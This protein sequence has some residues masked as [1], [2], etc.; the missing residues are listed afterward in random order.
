MST[1]PQ[2]GNPESEVNSPRENAGKNG[3]RALH[4]PFAFLAGSA[5]TFAVVIELLFGSTGPSV[6]ILFLLALG[7]VLWTI[8]LRR[9][10]TVNEKRTFFVYIST[11]GAILGLLVYNSWVGQYRYSLVLSGIGVFFLLASPVLGLWG[12]FWS[13][14]SERLRG[15]LLVVGPGLGLLIWG[16]IDP[17]LILAPILWWGVPIVFGLAFL[18][19]KR[20]RITSKWIALMGFASLLLPW[21]TSIESSFTGT[22]TVNTSSNEFL[23]DLVQQGISVQGVRPFS[24]Y[25]LITIL[26][27]PLIVIAIIVVG[28]TIFFYENWKTQRSDLDHRRRSAFS[29]PLL[30]VAS[31]MAAS[32]FT[33]VYAYRFGSVVRLPSAGCWLALITG[34][35]MTTPRPLRIQEQLHPPRTFAQVNPLSHLAPIRM[36]SLSTLPQTVSP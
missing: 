5:L 28:S 16:I 34:S 2:S 35:M 6:V 1:A 4:G 3:A 22:G 11:L 9:A 29:G 36:P 12:V 33:I 25:W 19:E 15:A 27:L 23:S 31:V 30:I 14:A 20:A 13:D 24:N 26:A 18:T 21:F 10:R 8:G 7:V 32:I 17:L